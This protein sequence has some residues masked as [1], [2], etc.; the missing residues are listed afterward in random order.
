MFVKEQRQCKGFCVCF[1]LSCICSIYVLVFRS[2]NW[3]NI[4]KKEVSISSI[5][6]LSEKWWGQNFERWCGHIR[7]CF[8]IHFN[9]IE[10]A[11]MADECICLLA[12]HGPNQGSNHRMMKFWRREHEIW[13]LLIIL[14]SGLFFL[15]PKSVTI[16]SDRIAK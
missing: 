14:V 9:S 6:F 16:P 15:K 1:N 4:G 13:T 10:N 8:S 3:K 2:R 7:L 5:Y 12:W 11:K